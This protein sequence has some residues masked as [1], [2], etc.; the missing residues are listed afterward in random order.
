[1][2]WPPVDQF[3]A[4]NSSLG[5]S[6]ATA[7]VFAS[8]RKYSSSMPNEYSETSSRPVAERMTRCCLSSLRPRRS[9]FNKLESNAMGLQ[10]SF[11]KRCLPE[12]RM[13][14]RAHLGL[15]IPQHVLNEILLIQTTRPRLAGFQQT[16][17]IV[18]ERT[19]QMAQRRHREIS[20][21]TVDHC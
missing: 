2:A 14:L 1:M 10:P 19:T 12:P 21:R 5:V 6:T 7:S 17:D 20:L 16:A 11:E 9:R 15:W 4:S 13:A 3:A 8:A 18:E